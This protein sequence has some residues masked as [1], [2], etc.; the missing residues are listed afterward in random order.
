MFK[1][2]LHRARVNVPA[3][4]SENRKAVDSVAV[5][6]VLFL[7]FIVERT[8]SMADPKWYWLIILAGVL[9]GISLILHSAGAH[10]KTRWASKLQRLEVALLVA[11]ISA[12]VT[13]MVVSALK[14][15]EAYLGLGLAILIVT[16]HVF[17]SAR[18]LNGAEVP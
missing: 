1:N 16:G 12:G 14:P 7:P 2:K 15:A 9:I 13:L 6:M 18:Q 5:V 10:A 4:A 17:I 8:M 11:F 3:E